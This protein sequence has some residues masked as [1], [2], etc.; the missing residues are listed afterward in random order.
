MPADH[1]FFPALCGWA[2]TSAL[3]SP[4]QPGG[5]LSFLRLASPINPGGQSA[6]PS[7]RIFSA[8]VE[9]NG[10]GFPEKVAYATCIEA[11]AGELQWG[12]FYG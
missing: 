4:F 8:R 2:Q 9:R 11:G 6:I 12:C 3:S 1:I 5:T 10:S 7:R